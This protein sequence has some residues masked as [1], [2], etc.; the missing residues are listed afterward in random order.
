MKSIL[1]SKM[2]FKLDSALNWIVNIDEMEILMHT[3]SEDENKFFSSFA[4]N[5]SLSKTILRAEVACVAS[6][7]MLKAVGN[8]S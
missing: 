3:L 4:K 5:I 7:S 1:E 8:V 6:V 2:K